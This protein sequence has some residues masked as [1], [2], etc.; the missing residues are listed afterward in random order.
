MEGDNCTAP[1]HR[2]K[3]SAQADGRAASVSVD[4]VAAVHIPLIFVFMSLVITVFAWTPSPAIIIFA[5][6]IGIPNPKGRRISARPSSTP[7]RLQ[8]DCVADRATRHYCTPTITII[9]ERLAKHKHPVFEVR[10]M[11]R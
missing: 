6:K 8:S 2:S 10:S 7:T 9:E 5:A 4:V 3:G 11:A 1:G